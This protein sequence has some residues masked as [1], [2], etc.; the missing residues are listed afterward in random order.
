MGKAQK[1][2][3]VVF[4]EQNGLSTKTQKGKCTGHLGAGANQQ[5]D[6]RIGEERSEVQSS[7]EIRVRLSRTSHLWKCSWWWEVWEDLGSSNENAG[8][9]GKTAGV[10]SM[11]ARWG[12]GRVMESRC[13]VSQKRLSVIQTLLFGT[14]IRMAAEK[15]TLKV[16]L[17]CGVCSVLKGQATQMRVHNS[18]SDE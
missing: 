11:Q 3:K 16:R 14:L 5:P 13:P 7:E 4:D 1:R 17:L 18:G 6:Q 8:G 15:T 9:V 10:R 12:G 2:E